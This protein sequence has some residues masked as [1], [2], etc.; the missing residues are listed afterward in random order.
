MISNTRLRISNYHLANFVQKLNMGTFRHLRYIIIP[1]NDY[2][3][4]LL[5]ILYKHG[6]IRTYMIV[7]DQIYIYFKYYVGK[8]LFRF[9]LVSKPSKRIYWNLNQL[10]LNYSKS[11]FCGFYIISTP[12]G[13]LTSH[14]CLLFE[15]ISG[16]VL[17]KVFF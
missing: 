14:D 10:S 1:V 16:E 17:L 7:K 3:L 8:I 5:A 6:V 15:H 11:N 13:L 2:H 9:K 12:K 4:L